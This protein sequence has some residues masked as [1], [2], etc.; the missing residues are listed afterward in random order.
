MKFY[1][2]IVIISVSIFFSLSGNA[3]DSIP[4]LRNHFYGGVHLAGNSGLAS[5][6]LGP[7]FFNDRLLIGVGYGYLPE[8]I[9]GVEVHS[10]VLKTSY[11]FSRGLI[12][13]KAK[14][15]LGVS[16]IYGIT[17][18]TFIKLPSY[19]PEEYYAQNA[20]HFSPYLGV[21][22][23]FLNQGLGASKFRLHAELGIVDTYLWYSLSNKQIHFWDV[24]NVSAGLYYHL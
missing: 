20:I 17:S 4:R 7:K 8:S 16:T 18:N 1:S 5:I 21:S 19:Y 24:C 2:L 13:K 15:Y 12:Y 22:V 9:N 23:P 10:V 6:I 14:W 3:Q 11:N